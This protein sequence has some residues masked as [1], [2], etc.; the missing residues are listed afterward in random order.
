VL[1]SR[2]SA[3]KILDAL[4]LPPPPPDASSDRYSAYAVKHGGKG[5]NLLPTIVPLRDLGRE[6]IQDGDNI[7]LEV[8]EQGLGP[9]WMAAV[10]AANLPKVKSSRERATKASKCVIA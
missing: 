4:K 7:V 9:E 2:H 6:V 8:G 10:K 3:G 1:N 5:V